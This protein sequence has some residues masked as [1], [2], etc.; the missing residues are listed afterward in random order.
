VGVLH[1]EV[2]EV[3]VDDILVSVIIPV[4][5]SNETTEHLCKTSLK[6]VRY[7]GKTGE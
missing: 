4:D 6:A 5:I 7:C 2:E 1:D 3:E